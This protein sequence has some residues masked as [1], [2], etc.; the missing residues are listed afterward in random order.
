MLRTAALAETTTDWRQFD[1]REARQDA[2][3]AE[4]VG[5]ATEAGF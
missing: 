1:D 4:L 2:I 5:A 3:G